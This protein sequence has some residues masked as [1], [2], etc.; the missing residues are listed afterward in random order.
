MTRRLLPPAPEGEADD[1]GDIVR[2]LVDANHGKEG[3]RKALSDLLAQRPELAGIGGDAMR[4]A[5]SSIIE[6]A[7]GGNALREESTRRWLSELRQELSDSGDGELHRLMIQRVALTWLALA[8][9]EESRAE[10]WRQG[11][12]RVD[13]EF[14]DRHVSRL[15]LDF[16]RACKALSWVRRL[17]KPAVVAQ[18]NIAEQ[19]QINIGGEAGPAR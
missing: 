9:A 16:T 2:T 18:V 8:A 5:E 12:S 4:L 14:W 19:Q 10:K 13:A 7:T 15:Q 11:I 17:M 6:V 3:S 1:R